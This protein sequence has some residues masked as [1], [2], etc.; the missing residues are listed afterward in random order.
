VLVVTCLAQASFL[1]K[2]SF[3]GANFLGTGFLSTVSFL[4]TVSFLSSNRQTGSAVNWAKKGRRCI[5]GTPV[6]ASDCLRENLGLYLLVRQLIQ[7]ITCCSA[8]W[9]SSK[10]MGCCDTS[11]SFSEADDRR[12][13][14]VHNYLFQLLCFTCDCVRECSMV[15]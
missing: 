10:E 14:Q 1:G 7:V 5:K 13:P 2:V 9:R 15:S 11:K 3:L 6:T 8:A 12:A 4:G